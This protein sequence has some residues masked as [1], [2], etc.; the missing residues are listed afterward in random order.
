MNRQ[1]DDSA[2]I[3]TLPTLYRR[4][5]ELWKKRMF[6]VIDAV[7]V[8]LETNP[9]EVVME[10]FSLSKRDVALL[11]RLGFFTEE[12]AERFDLNRIEAQVRA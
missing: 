3:E 2:Y 1:I 8:E 7:A 12:E 11:V 4:H 10:K 5:H 9:P 6:K